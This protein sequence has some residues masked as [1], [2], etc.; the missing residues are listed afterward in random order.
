M[1]K[2]R[3]NRTTIAFTL[4]DNLIEFGMDLQDGKEIRK[5]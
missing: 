4:I 3:K 5:F 1:R 2:D